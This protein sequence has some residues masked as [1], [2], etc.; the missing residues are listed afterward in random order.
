MYDI[1]RPQGVPLAAAPLYK[2][3]YCSVSNI[4]SAWSQY[5]ALKYVGFPTQV[6]C[7][8]SHGRNP[9]VK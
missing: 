6:S 5:E 7:R 3:S 2:F 8:A 1:V 9:D 4:V